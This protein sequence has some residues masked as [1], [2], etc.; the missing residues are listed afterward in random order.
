M[1][2][3]VEDPEA[4]V[5]LLEEVAVEHHSDHADTRSPLVVE[6]DRDDHKIHDHILG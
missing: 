3:A 2:G 4:M 6:V 1:V 5:G